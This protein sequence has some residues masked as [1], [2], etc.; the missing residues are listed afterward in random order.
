[1]KISGGILL[2]DRLPILAK[3]SPTL[4]L[5]RKSSKYGHLGT[6]QISAF[7]VS[8]GLISIDNEFHK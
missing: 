5:R 1:M 4:H 7:I 8:A 6:F 2:Q 3:S